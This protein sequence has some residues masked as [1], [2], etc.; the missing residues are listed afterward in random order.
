MDPLGFALENFNAI[1]QWRSLGVAG[2]T[3]D[4]SGALPDGTA[5]D[6]VEGLRSALMASDRF[7]E[8]LTE[9]LMTYALGRG[10]EYYDRPAVRKIVSDAAEDDHRLSAFIIGVVESVPFTQRRAGA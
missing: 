4:A 8:T 1:G 7:L 9:K 2:E 5:F 10:V 3:I 6:G